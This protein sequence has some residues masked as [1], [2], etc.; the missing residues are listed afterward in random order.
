MRNKLIQ[1][2][3]IK[4]EIKN[5]LGNP[6]NLGFGFIFPVFMGCLLITTVIKQIP[7]IAQESFKIQFFI[8]YLLFS[9]LA[10]VLIG[11]PSL[12]SQELESQSI[13]R[14][15]LYGYTN[16]SIMMSKLIANLIATVLGSILYIVVVGNVTGIKAPSLETILILIVIVFTITVL[17]FLLGYVISM[18]FKRFGP[19]FALTMPL[20]FMIM[21]ISGLMGVQ[22][23]NLPKF[24]TT[25]SNSIPV[26]YL[27]NDA[28]AL[29]NN[30][31][32]YN[33][34][35]LIQAYVIS[36]A[37]ILLALF[38]TLYRNRRTN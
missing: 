37:I 6:F 17:L 36:T 5:L 31:T 13:T 7:D 4:Y 15:N 14:L 30:P 2:N 23:E 32:T 11:F 27:V 29:W 1:I 12:F 18:F 35:P 25:L 10:F 19:T 21:I 8:G 26:S 9:P 33:Y 34:A 3:M 22:L 28:Y 20:Y 38:A 16:K 24:I